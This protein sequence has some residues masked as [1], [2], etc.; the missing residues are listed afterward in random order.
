ML[1]C[2][3]SCQFPL[4]KISEPVLVSFESNEKKKKEKKKSEL[5]AGGR[6]RGGD[7]K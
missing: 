5:K 7:E 3:L 4:F 6:E 2:W 1:K